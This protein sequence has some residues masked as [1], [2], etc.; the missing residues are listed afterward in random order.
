ME[1]GG[2]ECAYGS[3]FP[4][5]MN[6]LNKGVLYWHLGSHGGHPDSGLFLFWD[7]GKDG[8][9]RGCSGLQLPPGAA[10]AKETNPWRSYDWYLGS[11]EEPDTLSAE[12]HGIIPALLGNPNINGIARTAFDW[13]PAKKPVRD[14]IN[15][16]LA[17]IPI[18]NKILS[19]GRLDTQDYYDGQI[20]GA[21]V[22]TFGYSWYTGWALDD[23]L[24][25]LHSMVFVTG[26]C[27]VGGKYMHTAMVRHGAVCQII[28]P[29]STSWYGCVWMQSMPRDIILGDT[30]GEAYNKGISHV[31]I[32]HIGNDEVSQQWWW[33]NAENVVYYGDPDLRMFVPS[34]EY[35]D[36]NHWEQDDVQPIRYDE[37][38]DINGHMPF[39]ATDYPHE[40][41][42]LTFLQQYLVLIIAIAA[43]M[44][45]VIVAVCLPG[46]N[47]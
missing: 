13:A 28:D 20:C 45:L 1:K 41:E 16:L 27:L 15:N 12:I 5:T 31:G 30:I 9:S 44:V 43:I 24:E 26:V 47:K 14:N 34:I 42:P 2:F 19:K 46:K 40:K 35:S 37:E 10:A 29:W 4:D 39:G 33:D 8:P 23:A 22:S 21:F 38:L 3:N 17:K 7:S 36:A 11:T 25:N 6:N 32:I 18:I